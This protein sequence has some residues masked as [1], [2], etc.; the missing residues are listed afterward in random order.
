MM[1]GKASWLLMIAWLCVLMTG[2]WVY[3]GNQTVPFDPD[4]TLTSASQDKDFDTRFVS[5]MAK[6]GIAP[7]TIVH[8]E[9]DTPC[10]C[11]SLSRQHQ[12]ELT[13]LLQDSGY[14]F[15]T[16]NI[17]EYSSI[18]AEIPSFP[19]V[20]VIDSKNQLRY[21]G[22]YAT[23]LGCYTGDDLVTTIASEVQKPDFNGAMLNIAGEGC[24]CAIKS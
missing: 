6:A 19:A 3:G 15:K 23:G 20:A 13:N 11:N 12:K 16:L 21:L 1:K 17:N 2:L 14:N 9:A 5:E 7:G 24:Y 10:F 4:L 8:F 18:A 22:A